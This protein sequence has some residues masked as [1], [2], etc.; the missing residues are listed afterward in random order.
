MLYHRVYI[1]T[2]IN[3]YYTK[4]E[5]N[6]LSFELQRRVCQLLLQMGFN[7]PLEKSGERKWT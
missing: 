6:S 1:K 5:F 2:A 4:L 3:K 7:E